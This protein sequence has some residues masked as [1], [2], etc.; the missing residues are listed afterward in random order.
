MSKSKLVFRDESDMF[1]TSIMLQNHNKSYNETIVKTTTPI[2]NPFKKSDSKLEGGFMFHSPDMKNDGW[3]S[4]A[5]LL[6]DFEGPFSIEASYDSESKKVE[7][8]L[9]VA[10]KMDAASIAWGTI[11]TWEKWSIEKAKEAAEEK[12]KKDKIFVDENGNL[13]A[14]VTVNTLEPIPG[15]N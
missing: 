13:K 1:G 14:T 3:E 10:E 7:S 6:N 15:S 11:N 8:T 4:T 9:R 2:K 5:N 12:N